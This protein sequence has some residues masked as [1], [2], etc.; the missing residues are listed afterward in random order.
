ML[1]LE[2]DARSML[3]LDKAALEHLVRHRLRR[4]APGGHRGE[5]L[6]KGLG[7]ASATSFFLSKKAFCLIN[8]SSGPTS[9]RT[10]GFS[11]RISGRVRNR[12]CARNRGCE[13]AATG[14]NHTLREGL[15]AALLLRTECGLASRATEC[16]CA[17]PLAGCWLA[18]CRRQSH[19]Q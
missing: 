12:G 18:R 3:E 2:V 17:G 9:R 10:H 7:R 6:H 19:Q 5:R 16:S 15:S 11:A 14:Q 8:A 13:A 4:H 1:E